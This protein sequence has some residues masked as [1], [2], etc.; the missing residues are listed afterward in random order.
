MRR[1][2]GLA[3]ALVTMAVALGP[4]SAAATRHPWVVTDT[5]R[6][7]GAMCTYDAGDPRRRVFVPVPA[8]RILWPDKR[9]GRTD[10]GVV[11]WR[12]ELQVE[13]PGRPWH[14][15]YDSSI[16]R[17]RATDHRAA[18]VPKLAVNWRLSHPVGASYRVRLIAYWYRPGGGILTSASRTVHWYGLAHALHG[19]APGS[20]GGWSMGATLGHRQGSCPNLLP[21]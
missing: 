8:P 11:G 15:A 5:V 1:T 6:S 7:P 20:P 9:P 3:G 10:S 12:I 2:L 17:G 13:L 16:T 4:G 21:G 19:W 18:H 14:V